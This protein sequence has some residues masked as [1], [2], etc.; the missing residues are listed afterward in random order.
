MFSFTFPTIDHIKHFHEGITPQVLPPPIIS[1][2][3]MPQ[4]VMP[5]PGL[6]ADFCKLMPTPDRLIPHLPPFHYDT[7]NPSGQSIGLIG[8][9]NTYNDILTKVFDG[10]QGVEHILEPSAQTQ[11][12]E[13]LNN[14]INEYC[15][16][17]K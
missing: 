8:L 10:T 13:S 4:L 5:S 6:H 16:P 9:K 15:F 12:L 7:Q 14:Q 17:K 2:V 3:Q 1:H 11:M